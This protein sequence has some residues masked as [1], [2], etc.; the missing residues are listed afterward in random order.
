MRR[1]IVL[2]VGE[3][4]VCLPQS[5]AIDFLKSPSG[6][7]GGSP[8]ALFF[9]PETSS[10]ALSRALKSSRVRP[11]SRSFNEMS[12]CTLRSALEMAGRYLRNELSPGVAG[13]VNRES[14]WRSSPSVSDDTVSCPSEVETTCCLSTVP[15]FDPGKNAEARIL[16]GLTRTALARIEIA[17]RRKGSRDLAPVW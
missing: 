4:V 16:P 15:P 2:P 6:S 13:S 9:K 17:A 8:G 1:R 14:N 7:G 11:L 3:E 5:Q 10:T 12:W